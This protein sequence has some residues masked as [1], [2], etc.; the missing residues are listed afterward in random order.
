MMTETSPSRR[1]SELVLL[2]SPLHAIQIPKEIL[3]VAEELVS[4]TDTDG[5]EPDDLR[6]LI[7]M[8]LFLDRQQRSL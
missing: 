7:R 6:L 4:R 2:E 8:V 3:E 1:L 5:I